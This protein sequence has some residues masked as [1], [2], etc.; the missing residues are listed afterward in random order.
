LNGGDEKALA[1]R[2]IQNIL[3]NAA[4]ISSPEK[5][6]AA[7]QQIVSFW[8][9]IPKELRGRVT[10]LF[11]R[12]WGSKDVGITT[13]PDIMKQ[14]T[15]VN[16]DDRRLESLYLMLPTPDRATLRLGQTMKDLRS[17]GLEDAV[18]RTKDGVFT[19]YGTRG[20][21]IGHMVTTGD[22]QRFFI[23]CGERFGLIDTKEKINAKKNQILD[24][25]NWWADNYTSFVLLLEPSELGDVAELESKII[26]MAEDTSSKFILL[27]M[28]SSIEDTTKLVNILEKMKSDKKI[29]YKN[30][31]STCNQIPFPYE[32]YDELKFE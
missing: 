9:F 28:I 10:E 6:F 30:M 3:E 11:Q 5:M 18:S 1:L 25:F 14:S 16:F 31:E 23:E 12:F 32:C 19:H 20:L 17:R 24:R 4:R 21:S 27:H 7:L 22:I 29:D 13:D 15:E 26:S 8:K 2:V